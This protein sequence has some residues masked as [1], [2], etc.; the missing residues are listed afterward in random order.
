MQLDPTQ[1]GPAENQND[2]SV[3]EANASQVLR[4][5]PLI[6]N[7]KGGGG[8]GGSCIVS[9]DSDEIKM[10]GHFFILSDES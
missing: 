5:T 2:N 7:S 6:V 10:S 1:T 4:Y 8:V 3:A 9:E